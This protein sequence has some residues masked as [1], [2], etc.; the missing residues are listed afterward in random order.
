MS[1]TAG[2][3]DTGQQTDTDAA[4]AAAATGA[5]TKADKGQKAAN[6]TDTG[7]Q[8]TDTGKTAD[9][10]TDKTGKDAAA[11]PDWRDVITDA[12]QREFADRMASPADAVKS[13]FE[14]RQKLSKAVTLPGKDADEKEIAAFHKALGVPEAVDGYKYERPEFPETFEFTEGMQTQ[15]TAFIAKAHELGLTPTQL[16][17]VLDFHYGNVGSDHETVAKTLQQGREKAEAALKKE[18]GED[19]K[20]N[21]TMA[22]S[23]AKI[24]GGDEFVQFLSNLTAGGVQLSN[25][26]LVVKA[27]AEI[28]RHMGEHGMPLPMGDS[29]RQTVEEQ[30]AD[31]RQKKQEALD[32]G[33]R[34]EAERLDEAERAAYDKIYGKQP[35]VGQA[36][37]TV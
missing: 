3:E 30:V 20:A 29:E 31:I 13:A 1:D 21:T 16:K 18:W 5:D 7:T 23:A 11:Q 4:A 35:I 9:K 6:G 36:G 10:T 25:H 12:K 24:Y 32:K 2:A 14:M 33:D 15:E 22:A 28:G 37:R 19:Y 27:F 26:P 8:T 34:K 17:G